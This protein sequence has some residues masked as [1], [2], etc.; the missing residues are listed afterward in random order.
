MQ[1]LDTNMSKCSYLSLSYILKKSSMCYSLL[2]CLLF[3]WDKF[4]LL[5]LK[6]IRVYSVYKAK[7]KA[8]GKGRV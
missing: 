2:K 6:W 8:K 5:L 7:A 3:E 1:C 4:V